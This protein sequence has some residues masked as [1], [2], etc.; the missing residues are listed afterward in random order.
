M[1]NPIKTVEGQWSRLRNQV[2]RKS[3]LVLNNASS[4]KASGRRRRPADKLIS[5]SFTP[6]KI[7]LT[8]ALKPL[9]PPTR[10]KE[11][12]QRLGELTDQSKRFE[13]LA[14]KA[15]RAKEDIE[16]R[17]KQ[18]KGTAEELKALK[19]TTLNLSKT[20]IAKLEFPAP[21]ELPPMS[22]IGFKGATA[23]YQPCGDGYNRTQ[24]GFIRDP[25]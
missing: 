7:D 20:L 17:V 6:S 9:T 14:N 15:N 2:T 24:I 11:F 18:F 4:S 16:L 1:T 3:P 10:T 8:E 12:A 23:D 25:E 19:L 13:E 22:T 5:K 21:P